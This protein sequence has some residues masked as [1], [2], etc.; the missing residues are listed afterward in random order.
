MVVGSSAII[1]EILKVKS[2]MD[3]GMFYGIQKGAIQALELEDSWYKELNEVYANRRAI[4][5]Q[6]LDK[7]NCEFDKNAVG[8]FVW[9]KV[10]QVKLVRACQ[11]I[12][13]TKKTYLPLQI[14]FG[15]NG[16]NY[17]RMSLCIHEEALQKY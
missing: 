7:L 15:S 8:M 11:I 1:S 13:C 4:V 9:A 2:N 12:Y 17:I 5:Y 16:E 3:S 6:I 10:P 14:V